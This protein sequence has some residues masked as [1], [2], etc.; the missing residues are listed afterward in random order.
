MACW[1]CFVSTDRIAPNLEQGWVS[2]RK[3][4]SCCGWKSG[5]EGGKMLRKF[6]YIC[7]VPISR[8]FCNITAGCIGEEA[9]MH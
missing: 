1:L 5:P 9:D 4:R 8:A 6:Q 2:V 3:P 7:M